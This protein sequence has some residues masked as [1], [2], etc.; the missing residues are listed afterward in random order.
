[1]SNLCNERCRCADQRCKSFSPYSGASQLISQ[2]YAERTPSEVRRN[3]QLPPR[4]PSVV[5]P[6]SVGASFQAP[7][8][9]SKSRIP[10][11][12][13]M[14]RGRPTGTAQT[15]QAPPSTSQARRIGGDPFA[16]LD[17]SSVGTRSAEVDEIGSKF[18]ALDDFSILQDKKNGFKFDAAKTQNGS[19]QPVNSLVTQA[20]ADEAFATLSTPP[21]SPGPVKTKP[22]VPEKSR[23]PESPRSRAESPHIKEPTPQRPTMVSTGTMTSKPSSPVIKAMPKVSAKEIWRVPTAPPKPLKSTNRV[24]RTPSYKN[25]RP[26]EVEHLNRDVPEVTISSRP[27]LESLRPPAA[28]LEEPMHRSQSAGTR[29]RSSRDRIVS[30]SKLQHARRISEAELPEQPEGAEAAVENAEPAIEEITIASDLDYL[31]AMEE[32]RAHKG[33]STLHKH[34]KHASMPASTMS[35][36]RGAFSG[37]LGDTFRRFES[38]GSPRRL[39][40]PDGLSADDDHSSIPATERSEHDIRAESEEA[41]D[42]TEELSPEV[43]R[44]FERRQ[45]LLEERRVAEA[46]ATYRQRVAD[47]GSTVDSALRAPAKSSRASAIQDRVKTLL[48]ES[49]KAPPVRKTASGYG[50]F[51]ETSEEEADI[52]PP[53]SVRR[54]PPP[55]A[56][57]KT[58][59]PPSRP[60][61]SQSSQ[62]PQATRVSALPTRAPTARPSAPPKPAG[63]RK[64]SAAPEPAL[65]PVED[66]LSGDSDD[67][68][69]DF[70]KRYPSLSL[71]MVEKEI[72]KVNRKPPRPASMRV[73][74][75]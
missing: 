61:T 4:E 19:A 52:P 27:S 11:I 60:A 74:D 17:S 5:A 37:K 1:M 45:Q 39:P 48:E 15:I 66:S 57:K 21:R 18:P 7:L 43:R 65:P 16:A 34:H 69:S 72:S 40:S 14:R 13:P 62:E 59:P 58:A 63:L 6:P 29:S 64:V 67:L 73:R 51:T 23:K 53:E 32:E 8:P 68:E 54:Q 36:S 3:Q 56:Q 33:Q 38:E 75:V 70:S 55:I 10:D 35:G 31:R 24:T 46:A 2:I 12:T 9:E 28:H 26:D 41:I 49:N 25:A 42:E 20:L 71:E 50:R 30:R 44:E 47:R 22:T